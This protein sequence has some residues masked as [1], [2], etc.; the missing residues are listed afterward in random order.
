MINCFLLYVDDEEGEE[1][2]EIKM[3][4][5]QDD[6]FGDEMEKRISKASN[7][8]YA[9]LNAKVNPMDNIEDKDPGI[10]RMHNLPFTIQEDSNG[11]D[12]GLLEKQRKGDSLG[13][14]QAGRIPSVVP[15]MPSSQP[16]AM[17]SFA[18]TASQGIDLSPNLVMPAEQTT[19]I[20]ATGELPQMAGGSPIERPGI[21][22]VNYQ[23]SMASQMN[24]MMPQMPYPQV[25]S[26]M[27]MQPGVSNVAT[28]WTPAMLP[29][30]T[31]A[32][33]SRGSKM[34]TTSGIKRRQASKK[35]HVH[36]S[37]T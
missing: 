30:Q 12:T 9:L 7:Q 14:Q 8:D 36:K 4:N 19:V 10:I 24:S 5:N 1:S 33:I 15:F 32:Y 3:F 2:E 6:K 27:P 21:G 28:P 29:G 13:T 18:P 17:T 35:R 16:V 23:P 37:K 31:R 11:E 20:P 26:M 34:K 25:N 22:A